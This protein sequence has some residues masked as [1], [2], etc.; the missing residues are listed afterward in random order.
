MQFSTKLA[1]FLH[2]ERSSK[3]DIDLSGELYEQLKPF[4]FP[5]ILI[6]LGLIFGTL[7]YMVLEEYSLMEAFFQTSYTF[8]T[9]GF[10][11]L[12]ESDFN[13]VT[14]IFT[15]M[16]MLAGSAVLTFSV[17]SIIDVLNRGK[18]ISIIKERRMIYRVA[19][20]K[21]HF[22]V[23]YHNEYTMQL[24]E[25]FREAHI[26]FVVIDPSPDFEE[27]A[28]RHRYPYYINEDPH[29]EIAMRKS[30]L[31]S[32]KGVITLSKNIAD[33]IAQIVSVRLFEKEL[34]RRPYYLISTAESVEDVEKLKKLG[35]DTVVSATRLMAQ[36]VS[37]M[38]TRPDM[39]NLLEQFVYKQDTPL[40]LEEV[41][42][43]R[44]SW[45]VLKKLKEAHFREVTQVSIVGITQKDGKFITMPT[46]DTLITSE[47][48]LLMIG[49]S[50]GIRATKR[51]LSKHEKP[52]ELKYV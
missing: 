18:L 30:H 2:W 36:R 28:Q 48:K 33:N 40:D 51:L 43:P 41:F 52:E 17:V 38:A 14:I 31:S 24:A 47:C 7:G 45:L 50:N 20:L 21:N 39:E 16:L 13:G 44:S 49:T 23:C 29:T 27:Q 42:I 4:R 5:L 6:Q 22:V 37:A 26:P 19:R 34:G 32:A 3:P 9:T 1:R 10:G 12:G 46:G 25:Q 15:A 35:S 8:T 11:A